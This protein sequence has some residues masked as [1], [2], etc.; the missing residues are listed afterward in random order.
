MQDC[1]MVLRLRSGMMQDQVLVAWSD[2]NSLG[3]LLKGVATHVTS[4]QGNEEALLTSCNRRF[5][6]QTVCLDSLSI[7]ARSIAQVCSIIFCGCGLVSPASAQ[8]ARTLSPALLLCA[9][10]TLPAPTQHR[11]TSARRHRSASS[12]LTVRGSSR[13]LR[14]LYTAPVDQHL[15]LTSPRPTI[16]RSAA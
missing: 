1:R 13:R 15:A 11:T 4:C 5:H 3:I 7:L 9:T 6:L 10:E 2:F 16:T 14:T 8:I 12:T